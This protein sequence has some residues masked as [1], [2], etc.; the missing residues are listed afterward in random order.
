MREAEPYNANIMTMAIIR[1]AFIRVGMFILCL[2]I[3]FRPS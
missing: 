1:T 3:V 2:V